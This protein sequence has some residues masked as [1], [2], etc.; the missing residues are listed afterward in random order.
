MGRPQATTYSRTAVAFH[1][2]IALM[3]LITTGLALFREAFSA[4]DV[5]MISAHKITG[6]AILLVGIARLAWRIRHQPPPLPPKVGPREARI[7]SAAH[8]L[9]YFL[10]IVVP[11]AGWIFV[12]LAPEARPLD[13]RGVDNVPN[14]PLRVDDSASFAWHEV[15]E[16]LGFAFIGIFLLHVAGVLRH[17]L[18]GGGGVAERMLPQSRWLRLVIAAAV[19]L[20]TLGLSLDLFGV[21]VT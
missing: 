6:L 7:A 14:L 12:S 9:M 20:W 3:L 5:W 11:L 18:P 17:E 4:W 8:W 19:V 13:F 16:I 15:H 2:A 10:A 21:R 1:W